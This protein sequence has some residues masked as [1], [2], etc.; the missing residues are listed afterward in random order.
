MNPKFLLLQEPRIAASL[1]NYNAIFEPADKINSQILI[2]V[3]I[4]FIVLHKSQNLVAIQVPTRNNVRIVIINIYIHKPINDQ[5]RLAKNQII[6]LIQRAVSSGEIV[7]VG[8]DFNMKS[9]SPFMQ[10]IQQYL[11]FVMLPVKQNFWRAGGR[12]NSVDFI[13]SNL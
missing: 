7:I 13:L 1:P 11:K 12:A 2:K 10:K 6:S 9:S 3:G 8:G 5:T 4:E